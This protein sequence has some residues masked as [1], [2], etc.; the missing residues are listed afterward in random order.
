MTVN[1]GKLTGQNLTNE[2]VRDGRSLNKL[3]LSYGKSISPSLRRTAETAELVLLSHSQN[4]TWSLI[5]QEKKPHI[6]LVRRLRH[7]LWAQRYLGWS[8]TH[9]KCVSWS[10]KKR[11]EKTHLC[12]LT[13][14]TKVRHLGSTKNCSGLPAALMCPWQ[15]L[16]DF[17]TKNLQC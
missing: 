1:T 15:F 16:G 14:R 17:W 3:H 9:W 13:D 10:E 7:G 6:N 5:V 8:M 12:I 4:V 11:K 2:S